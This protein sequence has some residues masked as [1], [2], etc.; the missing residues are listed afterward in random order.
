M[1]EIEDK[2]K[3]ENENNN[4]VVKQPGGGVELFGE[5]IENTENNGVE[6]KDKLGKPGEV[7]NNAPFV[8]IDGGKEQGKSE[9]IKAE[10]EPMLHIGI[11][12][13][14]KKKNVSSGGYDSSTSAGWQRVLQEKDALRKAA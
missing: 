1:T 4:E 5:G 6:D 12:Y 13:T 3:I 7:K 14:V 11:G 10:E 9:G 2:D 8:V